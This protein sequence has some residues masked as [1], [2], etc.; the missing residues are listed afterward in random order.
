MREFL[1][2]DTMLLGLISGALVPIVLFFV[3]YYL[4]TW[5]EN[6]IEGHRNFLETNTIILISIVLNV[7]LLR[8]FLTSKTREKTGRGVLIVTFA[9]SIAYAVIFVQSF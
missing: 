8:N 3:I 9:Y 6:S 5:L 4:N 7:F 2:K 1:K